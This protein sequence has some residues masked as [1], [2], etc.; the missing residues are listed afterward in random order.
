VLG[1]T[2]AFLSAGVSSVVAT[3]WPV[4]DVVTA[5]LMDA[6]YTGLADGKTVA[7]ALRGAQ[8]RIRADKKTRH[9]FYW[10]GF[11]VVGDGDVSVLIER[12]QRTSVIV[13]I[14]ICCFI[15]LAATVLARARHK[16]RHAL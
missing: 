9:P 3:L 7:S 2:S 10:A 1:L 16:T 4:D 14:T 12:Q 6:F 15:V 13:M 8:L 5:D 11:V